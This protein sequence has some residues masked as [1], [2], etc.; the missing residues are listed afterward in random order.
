MCL[1]LNDILT[2]IGNLANN[3]TPSRPYYCSEGD[4]QAQLIKAIEELRPNLRAVAEYPN[5]VPQPTN[6]IDI[7]AID[8]HTEERT[9]IELKY[10]TRFHP[11]DDPGLLC[12]LSTQGAHNRTRVSF[13][14]DIARLEMT[15]ADSKFAILLTNDHLYWEPSPHETHDQNYRLHEGDNQDRHITGPLTWNTQPMQEWVVESGVPI[16]LGGDYPL[17]WRDFTADPRF[18]YLLI[19]VQ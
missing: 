9:L 14:R 6:Y 15:D 5:P 18:R 3:L 13:I 17:E 1:T 11:A 4:F 19:E 8:L 7:L 12:N 10:K 16:T 2:V